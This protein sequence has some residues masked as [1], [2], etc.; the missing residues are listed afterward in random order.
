MAH[1]FESGLMVG[2]AAW[3]GLGMVV[4]A[5]SDLRFDIHG[6]IVASGLDWN[7]SLEPQYTVMDA[8][9]YEVP[10][11]RSVVRRI[12]DQ[13]TILGSVGKRYVP[14]QNSEAFDWFQPWLE[15]KEVA[16]ET[17]GSLCGGRKVWVMA[18]IQRDD[19]SVFGDK[20]AKYL[21]LSNTHDGTSSIRVG[22]SPVRIV[23]ANTLAMA[24]GHR[25]SKL[26]RVRHTASRDIAMG[27]I[28]ETIDLID[29]E[30]QATTEQY[31]RLASLDISHRD[32]KRYI[33]VVFGMPEDDKDL[34]AK[35]Q[36]RLETV[37]NLATSGIGQTG[38]L[39]AWAGF[40]A[41]TQFLTHEIGSDPEQRLKSLWFGN[42]SHTLSRAL[43]L[44]LQL[45]S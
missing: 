39:T 19:E 14:M 17:A 26:L 15:S 43:D 2:E 25:D 5:D 23:C 9:I 44:A 7:V 35:A 30:F 3:H 32:L 11:T 28:R 31:R 18:R 42:N 24:H 4:P 29:R 20:V 38:E 8:Q 10:D 12:G 22:F 33:K 6:A 40:N 16:I 36:K 21:M 37:V 41:V 27:E 34:S 1:A 45:A 13:V